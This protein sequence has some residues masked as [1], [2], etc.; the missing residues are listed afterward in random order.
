[1]RDLS[2]GEQQE[3]DLASLHAHLKRY[4]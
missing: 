3:I 4:C 2:S 1:V